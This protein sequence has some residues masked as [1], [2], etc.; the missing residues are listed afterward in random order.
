MTAIPPPTV[1]ATWRP[2]A[3]GT[4]VFSPGKLRTIA[5][6]IRD[7]AHVVRE[8]PT[9]PIGL[10][11]GG[12]V[13]PVGVGSFTLLG[14]LPPTYPEWLGDRSFGEVHGVRFPYIVGE[15]AQGVATARMVAAA[16][17][18]G[19]LA[20]FGAAGLSIDRVDAALREIRTALGTRRN[21][22]VNLIHRPDAPADEERLADLAVTLGV[23]AVSASAFM[24][25]T[26]A[27]IYCAT[28]G[29]RS[30]AAG[31]I[32]RARSVVAKVSRPEI[33]RLFMSP[34]PVAALRDLVARGRIGE[35]EAALAARGPVA[36]DVTVEA[37]SAG[38]TDNRPLVAILPSIL[39]I[40]DELVALHGY[41][42]PVRVGA[43]G[44]LATPSAVAAA[45]ALGAAYV[46][47][48]SIN[49]SAVESGLSAS[50]RMMLAAADLADVAMAPSADMF[51]LGV[52]VQVLKR[53]TLFAARA[54]KLYDA[55]VRH[56][57]IE[58]LPD[59]VRTRLE[60]EVFRTSMAEAWKAT[61]RYWRE[62]DAAE[63]ERAHR[64]PKHR[65]ALTFRSYLGQSSGWAISGD[66]SRQ[67]DYQIWCGPAMGAFNRW[68]A[69]SF[70]ADPEARTVD[71]IALN[72]L[73]G[74]AVVGRAQ[75]LRSAGV[76]MP[77]SAF[78]YRPRR[79]A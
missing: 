78:D 59:A 67:A 44:G 49:Q 33:A 56:D 52:K 28:A 47:T 63:V 34:P 72:L 39:T 74:A 75:Q 7:V 69:G 17:N 48:G 58:S 57:A 31:R 60:D 19:V 62:R 24:T 45:F 3:D 9:G 26:P 21:W 5:E 42:R 46:L 16:A 1:A 50:A 18:A 76:P 35:E 68:V 14:S 36:E 43:A 71:Q 38:H 37:D 32:V 73:E 20:F 55:Y 65:M 51:E 70:L 54:A 22:G 10:A 13:S 8:S 79:L 11:C 25:L 23:P 61:E 29:I 12:D 53:G 27:V 66:M 6:R 15:M 4:A 2:G 64:D 41:A 77:S 40:R 30:D